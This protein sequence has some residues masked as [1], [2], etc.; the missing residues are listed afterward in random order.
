MFFTGTRGAIQL[1]Q[2]ARGCVRH[3]HQTDTLRSHWDQHGQIQKLGSFFLDHPATT[4]AQLAADSHIFIGS[5][6]AGGFKTRVAWVSTGLRHMYSLPSQMT[7]SHDPPVYIARFIFINQRRL[8]EGWG[9][10]GVSDNL[11]KCYII[12]VELSI[13][14]KLLQKI[15]SFFF[16]PPCIIAVK[17]NCSNCQG[18]WQLQSPQY[19]HVQKH[20]TKWQNKI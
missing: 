14:V 10:F 20:Y 7:I 17:T 15:G 2:L 16:G 5:R 19:I 9:W 8:L 4:Q 3:L 12:T 11:C 6:Y 1:S 13:L 18:R